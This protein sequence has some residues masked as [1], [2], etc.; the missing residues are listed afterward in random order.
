[1]PCN[2]KPSA[3]EVQQKRRCIYKTSKAKGK[4]S[5]PI[6]QMPT[7]NQSSRAFLT[8]SLKTLIHSSSQPSPPQEPSTCDIHIRVFAIDLGRFRDGTYTPLMMSVDVMVEGQGKCSLL[9]YNSNVKLLELTRE[10]SAQK[11]AEHVATATANRSRRGRRDGT[12]PW[13]R[14]QQLSLDGRV[15]FGV[16]QFLTGNLAARHRSIDSP[17]ADQVMI[18]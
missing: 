8:V 2:S 4:Q 12:S 7:L 15:S 10:E 11:S 3:R 16:V 14:V 13:S 5:R 17:T 1:M 6:G 9:M 18:Q